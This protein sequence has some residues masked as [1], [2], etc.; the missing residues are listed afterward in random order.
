MFCTFH[1]TSLLPSCLNLFWWKHTDFFMLIL[2]PATMPNCLLGLVNLDV[3]DRHHPGS[4][5]SSWGPKQR[6][7]SVLVPQGTTR[8]DKMQSHHL[9]RTRF[10]P[11][12]PTTSL[13]CCSYGCWWARQWGGGGRHVNL[14][15]HRFLELPTPPLSM[16]SNFF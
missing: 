2:Y 3:F 6:E 15:R 5:S 9:L 10:L 1:C 8:Q 13:C 4:C 7:A 16:T 11:L 14:W 12:S